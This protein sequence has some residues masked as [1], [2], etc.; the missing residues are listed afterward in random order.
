MLDTKAETLKVSFE[1]NAYTRAVSLSLA[2]L[3]F[4][5]KVGA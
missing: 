4:V 3:P 2:C 1:T 5:I